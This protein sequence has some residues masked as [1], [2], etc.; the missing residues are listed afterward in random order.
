M[1][2]ICT[3]PFGFLNPTL[4]SFAF[5][6]VFSNSMVVMF[7]MNSLTS[8]TSNLGEHFAYRA[9]PPCGLKIAILMCRKQARR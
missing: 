1:A 8:G 4:A 6:F 7:A 9:G 2:V 5:D 3:H